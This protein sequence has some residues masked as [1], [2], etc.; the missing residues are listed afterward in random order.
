MTAEAETR[1]ED[2]AGV[3]R[4][5]RFRF[6]TAFTVLFFVLVLV[7]ILTFVITPGT[8]SL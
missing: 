1:A 2:G 6:P 4:K 5:R 8:Y 3:E 7:W